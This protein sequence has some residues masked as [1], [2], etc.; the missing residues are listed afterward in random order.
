MKLKPN[1]HFSTNDLTNPY[2]DDV[3]PQTQTPHSCIIALMATLVDMDLIYALLFGPDSIAAK[4]QLN[5]AFY[6]R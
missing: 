1:N 3:H 6:V 5:S 4:V 2:D